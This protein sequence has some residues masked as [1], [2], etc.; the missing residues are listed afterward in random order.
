MDDAAGEALD[1]TA[2]LL[3]LEYPGGPALERLAM[4]GDARRFD[5]PDAGKAE[6]DFSFSGLKTAAR[7]LIER[8]PDARADIAASFQR[9]VTRALA[10]RAERALRR[11]GI[12]RLAA[13]GGVAQ[14]DALAL[15]LEEV[16]R[17][18]DAKL[19]RPRPE[20]CADNA[21]MI[22]LAGARAKAEK[23]D[24]AFDIRPRWL[25]GE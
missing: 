1:K 6:L 5:F 20:F 23:T 17:K 10:K 13:T 8:H 14:N 12:R 4:A 9:T 22:A 3:G 11:T 16:A 2:T 19:F 7:R 24:G 21:A 18:A 25:P 15:A